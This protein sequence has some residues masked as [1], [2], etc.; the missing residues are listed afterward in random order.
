MPVRLAVPTPTASRRLLVAL[1]SLAITTRDGVDSG[2][3]VQDGLRR[4]RPEAPQPPDGVSTGL[5]RQ[6]RPT[7]PRAPTPR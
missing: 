3:I 4:G 6:R 7:R 5:R 1:A 2:L